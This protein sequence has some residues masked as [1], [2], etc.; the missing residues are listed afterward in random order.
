MF[1]IAWSELFIVLIVAIIVVGPK[2]LPG[3]LRAFGRIVGKLR[4]SAD[5]FRRQFEESMR[6]AGGDDLQRELNEL[7][8]NNPL[9]EIRNTIENAARE[10]SQPPKLPA[11]ETYIDKPEEPPVAHETLTEPEVKPVPSLAPAT[12]ADA[13]PSAPPAAPAPTA[14]PEAKGG[15]AS[16]PTVSPGHEPLIN[17][18][19]RPLS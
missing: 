10:A 4:R 5:E 14:A 17:G 8:R 9:N 1:E 18:Q 7:R 13:T 15:P 12:P 19:H 16:E 11:P 6:E 2:E 3:M